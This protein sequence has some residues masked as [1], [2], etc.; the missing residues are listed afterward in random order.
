MRIVALTLACAFLL[1]AC[2]GGSAP[3][4]SEEPTGLQPLPS[5]TS[6]RQTAATPD[7]DGR[8]RVFP[9]SA[10]VEV[11]VPYRF[12]LLTRCGLDF[13]VDFN[14][15]LWETV[16]PAGSRAK[17]PPPGFDTPRDSGVM[18]LTNQELAEYE[19]SQGEVVRFVRHPGKKKIKPCPPPGG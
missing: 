10:P 7:A 9:T 3:P 6:H 12:R 2:N 1:S 14:G 8:Y 16:D 18:T 4:V 17:G 13:L 19:S 15:A 5:P 11:G